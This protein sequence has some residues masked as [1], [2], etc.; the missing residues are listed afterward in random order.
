MGGRAAQ[1]VGRRLA[2]LAEKH[3]VIVVTHLAQ[4]AAHA[5]T[6]AVVVKEEDES[7]AKTNVTIVT[8]NERLGELARM[9]SGNDTEAARTHAA[10]LLGGGPDV[11]R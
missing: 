10:E 3:Q 11:A 2:K 6:Q 8:G 4:V 1:A 9:L 5:A 7:G